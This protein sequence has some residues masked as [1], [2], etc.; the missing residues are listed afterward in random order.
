MRSP[1]EL[2]FQNRDLR[3]RS[4]RNR[5]LDHADF[6]GSD[7]RGCDFSEAS[8]QGACFNGATLGWTPRQ[9]FRLLWV[10]PPILLLADA[11]TRLM[12]G[13]LG[14]TPAENGWFFVL[15]LYSSLAIAGL[16]TVPPPKSRLRLRRFWQGLVGL[17]FGALPGF[18][19]AGIWTNNDSR[20]AIAGAVLGGIVAL[21]LSL[22]T[23]GPVR[24]AAFFSMSLI[25]AYG[26]ALL[27]GAWA[28]AFF[29]VAEL[30]PGLSM[31]LSTVLYLL[32]T[33]QGG[34]LV[35]RC[36]RLAV[37]TCFH[38]ANLKDATFTGVKLEAGNFD[39]LQFF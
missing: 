7:L 11:V 13:A 10:I 8:L 24:W 20:W 33:L 30:L 6:S 4:F 34:W 9:L 28:I 18:C 25:A 22:T 35:Y 36:V 15:V 2:N 21:L 29:A 19:Y 17:W 37:G 12:F 31:A 27:M 5:I 38:K 3:D 39:S 14:R 32:L 1:P 26:F 23:R 16:G